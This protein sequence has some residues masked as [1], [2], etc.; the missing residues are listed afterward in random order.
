MAKAAHAPAAG[1][2]RD[3][4]HAGDQQSQ[5]ASLDVRVHGAMTSMVDARALALLATTW[6][7]MDEPRRLAGKRIAQLAVDTGVVLLVALRV[8]DGP[9]RVVLG[10]PA[11]FFRRDGSALSVCPYFTRWSE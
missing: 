1:G 7:V 2:P 6:P 4:G 10:R 3:A 5:S 11:F 9:C 8:D